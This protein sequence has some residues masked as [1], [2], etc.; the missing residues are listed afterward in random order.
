MSGNQVLRLWVSQLLRLNGHGTVE[1][2]S[3][4]KLICRLQQSLRSSDVYEEPRVV[5]PAE[6]VGQDPLRW[7][8]N[9]V[10]L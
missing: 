4:L 5:D 6:A 9:L 1:T 10:I 2:Y 3:L 7:S 8:A